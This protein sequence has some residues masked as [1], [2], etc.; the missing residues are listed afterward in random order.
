MAE[1]G[2]LQFLSDR[3]D[4]CKTTSTVLESIRKKQDP[5]RFLDKENVREVEKKNIHTSIKLE[6][7]F[8][9]TDTSAQIASST[10]QLK[11]NGWCTCCEGYKETP[12]KHLG[13]QATF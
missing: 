9:D 11:L 1:T 13:K 10:D 3:K 7:K 6:E 8:K 12:G 5:K 4:W 2:A